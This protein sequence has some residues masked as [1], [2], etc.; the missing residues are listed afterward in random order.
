MNV[1]VY[2]LALL[3]TLAPVAVRADVVEAVGTETTPIEP[4]EPAAPEPETDPK[5]EAA[6]LEAEFGDHLLETGDAYRAITAYKKARFLA[7]TLRTGLLEY[8]VALAYLAGGQHHAAWRASRE[9]SGE[10]ALEQAARRLGA[11]ALF[12]ASENDA[13]IGELGSDPGGW[14]RYQI[15][16]AHLMA[17]RTEPAR[18][19]FLTVPPGDP[20]H[21]A[22]AGLAEALAPPVRLP[23]RSPVLAGM[24][25]IVPGLGHLYLGDVGVAASALL[26]NGAFGFGLYQTIRAGLW[27]LTAL[28]AV[29]ESVWYFGTIYGAVA[30]AHRFNRDAR[31]NWAD[32]LRRAYGPPGAPPQP[33]LEG[34]PPLAVE[35]TLP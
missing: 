21:R 25:S 4:A 20:L 32:E 13:A 6:T 28:V 18:A 29:L 1:Y 15:G 22:A 33:A 17:W 9:V 10:P 14:A 12:A 3:L 31:L 26:W 23:H 7:P 30:G 16:W 27:G 34:V 8:R 24:L 2:G 11:A 19:A 5:L 35:L